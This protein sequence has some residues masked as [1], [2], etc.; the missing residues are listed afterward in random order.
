MKCILLLLV[1]S[2]KS[3]HAADF[4][5]TEV[6]ESGR[7]SNRP[8]PE[9]DLLI[10]QPEHNVHVSTRLKLNVSGEIEAF[11]RGKNT[12]GRNPFEEGMAY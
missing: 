2:F 8:R 12:E 5:F 7:G 9:P 11:D 6:V 3:I 4:P 10:I 1:H